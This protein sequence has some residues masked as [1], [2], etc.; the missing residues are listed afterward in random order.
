MS[1]AVFV[2]RHGGPEILSV[3]ER[4][5]GAPQPGQVRLRQTAIGLNFVDTY[6]RSGLYAVDLPF[7]AGNEGAGEV[8]AVGEEVDDFKPG[9]RVAYSGTVGAYA[10]ERLIAAD[11]LVHVPDAVDDRT[12]AAVMLKG[13]T[14]YF[15][16][17]ET[18]PVKPGDAILFHAAAGGVGLIACQW[19]AALGAHVIGTAGS[20]E[21]V[22]MALSN[23]CHEAI[24]YRA[25]DFAPKVRALTGG[26]GVDV[27]YDGVGKATFEGSLD[28]LRPRG[29]LVSFGNASGPVAVPNL[30]IL[31]SK[32][33]LYLTRPTSSAYF[34][35]PQAYRKA[36]A[37]LFAAVADGSIAVTI[38]Q[39]FPLTDARKAHEALEARE[40]VGST[41]LVPRGGKL[42]PSTSKT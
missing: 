35:T 6:Q 2:R 29:L 10:E 31:A 1:K 20:P 34:P 28:S 22:A 12:A 8:L 17:H 27:V 18:W 37:A 32:G 39:T 5:L 30:G 14:A 38:G 41:V 36:A 9:D 3:E 4:E 16:L 42:L 33:S 24:D 40:T 7:V 23:G 26:R 13:T 25:E 15:L 21:K 19:A 11:K